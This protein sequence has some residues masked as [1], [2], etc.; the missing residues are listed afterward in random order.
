MKPWVCAHKQGTNWAVVC[1]RFQSNECLV[2]LNNDFFCVFRYKLPTWFLGLGRPPF[3]LTNSCSAW[4][5][6]CNCPGR[7]NFAKSVITISGASSE[8]RNDFWNDQKKRRTIILRPRSLQLII[9]Y[10]DLQLH[11]SV[12]LR[13]LHQE[14]SP[15]RYSHWPEPNLPTLV[16]CTC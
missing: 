13:L 12:N 15:L 1:N 14:T 9:P 7:S 3:C 5:A 8:S 2:F 4:Y 10:C 11:T 16:G 6:M